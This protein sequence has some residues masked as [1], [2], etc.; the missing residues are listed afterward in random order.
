[1]VV[2]CGGTGGHIYPGIAVA[3][4]FLRRSSDDEV[5]FIGSDSGPEARLVP[6]AGFPFRGV[7]VS[8]IRGKGPAARA[9][10]LARLPLALASAASALVRIRPH[11][12]LG[13]GGFASGPV[14]LGAVLLGRPTL[15]QEQNRRLGWTN[16]VLCP[17]VSEL[18]VSFPETSEEIGRGIVCGNPVREE[19]FEVGPPPLHP[20]RLSLLVFGGSQGARSLNRAVVEALP[21]LRRWEGRLFIRHQTGVSEHRDV[22]EAYRAAGF[23]PA[24]VVAY[25]DPMAAAFR[26]ADAVL[27][28]AGAST[29]AELCAAGRASVLVPYPHAT[30]AHQDDN[31]EALRARGAA[32]VVRDEDLDG[33]AVVR[34][35]E[36]FL[37]DPALVARRAEAARSLARPDASSCIAGIARRL[38][39]R[40][41]A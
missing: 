16:R 38:G 12:V 15:I 20:D 29:V 19:F 1:M 41:E 35:V 6:A 10:G 18:A 40:K 23:S 30:G 36:G 9:R 28:R 27:C 4:E 2:A 7:P 13:T 3:R 8:G 11:V 14:L 21:A 24:E 39:A 31:A 26:E 34:I 32:E 5:F 33:A 17:L 22:I 37:A 25:I